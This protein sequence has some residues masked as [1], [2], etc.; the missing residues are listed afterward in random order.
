MK[1]SKSDCA[2]A[3][4]ELNKG[5][6]WFPLD[7]DQINDLQEHIDLSGLSVE[8]GINRVDGRVTVTKKVSSPGN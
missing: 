3:L 1:L 4:Q 6:H 2:I 7:K 5:K 8:L